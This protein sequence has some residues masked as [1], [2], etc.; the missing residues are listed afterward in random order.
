[1]A[2]SQETEYY[3]WLGIQPSATEEEIKKAYRKLALR[4]HPDK[5]PDNPE[6][7]ER[8]K[9]ISEAYQVLSDPEKREKYDKLGKDGV[10]GAGEMDINALIQQLFGDGAFDH[11]FGTVDFSGFANQPADD[12]PEMIGLTEEERAAKM[13]ERVQLE[14]LEKIIELAG[15][16]RGRLEHFIENPTDF[17]E[18]A[19]IEAIDLAHAPGGAGLLE[20]LGY[21]YE[22]EAAQHMGRFFGVEGFFSEMREGFHMVKATFSLIKTLAVLQSQAQYMEEQGQKG[23]LSSDR[24][25]KMAASIMKEGL[26]LI[27]KLGK[28]QIEMIVRKVCEMVLEEKGVHS[29]ILKKRAEGLRILGET[30][31]AAGAGAK[32]Q[33][34]EQIKTAAAGLLGAVTVNLYQILANGQV[35]V[36]VDLSQ[37]EAGK[38][39]LRLKKRQIQVAEG[40]MLTVRLQVVA[41]QAVS[42]VRVVE[43]AYAEGPMGPMPGGKQAFPVGPMTAEQVFDQEIFR[44]KI[45][46]SL[47]TPDSYQR[48]T[49]IEDN[50][51]NCF[52]RFVLRFTKVAHRSQPIP[53][54]VDVTPVRLPKPIVVRP[55]TSPDPPPRTAPPSPSPSHSSPSPSPTPSPTPSPP[56]EQ[57]ST[58]G[59]SDLAD[60]D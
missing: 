10:G 8:F 31:A 38:K 46:K 16:L 5:N 41:N 14:N 11:L 56:E 30:F 27:W 36:E 25:A 6:A 47:F 35:L 57:S 50:H 9:Q 7:E 40:E 28:F 18:T 29:A 59:E 17:L 32:K 33:E 43:F 44:E 15:H 54:T 45:S 21:I 49:V 26:S 3:D 52:H 51:G 37:P 4:Y 55:P 23:E 53:I 22:Q 12:D 42:G 2:S 19:K 1:M 34:K 24:E 13:E 60:L 58:A 20:H 39:L 48:E